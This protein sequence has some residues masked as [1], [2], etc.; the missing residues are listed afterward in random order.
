[1]LYSFLKVAGAEF[2]EG[3]FL[4]GRS[5]VIFRADISGEGDDDTLKAWEIVRGEGGEFGGVW[6]SG[7]D[8]R[9]LNPDF[10]EELILDEGRWGETGQTTIV[11][12]DPEGL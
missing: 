4:T 9:S 2:E 5:E 6:I 7:R 3:R 12:G 1:M 10:S 11:I 8:H